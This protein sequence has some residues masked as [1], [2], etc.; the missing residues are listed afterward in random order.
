MKVFLEQGPAEPLAITR[1][2][3]EQIDHIHGIQIEILP[4]PNVNKV[5]FADQRYTE[6]WKIYTF[7]G[8]FSLSKAISEK[9]VEYVPISVSEIPAALRGLYCPDIALIQVT[10]PDNCGFCNFGLAADYKRTVV[11]AAR[12]TIAQVNNRM[13]VTCGDTG[14]H[15][16]DIDYIMEEDTELIQVAPTNPGEVEKEIA[17]Y[18]A[19]L[20]P[21][22]S[23]IQIG[24]GSVPDAIL[25]ALLDKHDLGIHSGLLSDRILDLIEA[26]VVTGKFKNLNPG[27][28][29]GALLIGTERL[30]RFCDRNPLIELYSVAYTHNRSIASQLDNFVSINS[31]IEVDLTGQVNTAMID[32]KQLAGVGGQVD[33]ARIARLSKGGISIIAIPSIANGKTKIVPQL[34]E[35]SVTRTDVDFVVTEYGIANLRYRSLRERANA[36]VEIAHPDFRVDLEHW[37]QKV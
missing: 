4:I 34:G 14:V 32:G 7:F 23:V 3:M 19:D 25:T 12:T 10:G 18:V 28:V 37:A 9:R 17:G 5:P 1:A 26:G 30:Y 27:K 6:H 13:P 36:L 29:V 24:I 15:L 21:D 22:R 16:S 35:V 31:A 11:E 8:G 33:Y 2:L 20:V